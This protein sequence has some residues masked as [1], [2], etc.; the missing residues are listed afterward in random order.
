[1]NAFRLIVS[2]TAL[3]G[4]G[5]TTGCAKTSGLPKGKWIDL[6]DEYSEQTVY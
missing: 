1:M 6:T 3:V 4:L 2:M 5:L